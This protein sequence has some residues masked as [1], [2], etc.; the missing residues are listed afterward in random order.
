MEEAENAGGP[1]EASTNEEAQPAAP[2][3]TAEVAG[4]KRKWLVLWLGIG[5]IVIAAAGLLGWRA[6]DTA[7]QEAAR[8]AA[9]KK[10][11]A[12]AD[13]DLETI[14]NKLEAQDSQWRSMTVGDDP[15]QLEGAVNGTFYDMRECR[16]LINGIRLKMKDV[17]SPAV[18]KAYLATC[19]ALYPVVDR[20]V[21]AQTDASAT[22]QIFANLSEAEN[23]HDE[24]LDLV[25]DAVKAGNAGKH[26]IGMKKA[27]QAKKLFTR[28]TSVYEKAAKKSTD[29][30]VRALVPYAKA[31]IVL[32]ELQYEL[33]R[34]GKQGGVSSYNR[35]IDKLEAHQKKLFD[36]ERKAAVDADAEWASIRAKNGVL[37]DQARPA[38]ELWQKAKIL[39]AA[40]EF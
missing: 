9:V 40:E 20:S 19:D 22:V 13:Q 17:D 23:Y 4:S 3:P 14:W 28:A 15:T 38:E 18:S 34:L 21:M 25:N 11:A 35:Q 10:A 29:P 1:A 12:E 26:D 7:T 8:V 39:V 6:Y 36:L 16:E 33:H 31:S 24:G 37:V 30:A 27:A 2:Q 32:A 5:L